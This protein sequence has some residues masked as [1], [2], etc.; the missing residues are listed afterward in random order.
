M[1]ELLTMADEKTLA[2]SVLIANRSEITAGK[3][4]RRNTR[5]S[6]RLQVHH[7]LT[8]SVKKDPG[9]GSVRKSVC[10]CRERASWGCPVARCW[11]NINSN[12]FQR[13]VAPTVDIYTVS[14]SF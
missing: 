7:S 4:H 10:C 12:K 2:E 13:C 5:P 11:C 3:R 9:A 8:A 14:M 6:L 1:S